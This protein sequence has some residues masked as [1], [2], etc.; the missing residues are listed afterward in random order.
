[1]IPISMAIYSQIILIKTKS[2]TNKQ[3]TK[4]RMH[5]RQLVNVLYPLQ[6]LMCA[7]RM[8]L[9]QKQHACK[10]SASAVNSWPSLPAHLLMPQDC[11]FP[12]P[13]TSPSHLFR[14]EFISL[15]PYNCLS[16][17]VLEIQKLEQ[18]QPLSG[19]QFAWVTLLGLQF[20]NW[21]QWAPHCHLARVCRIH[22]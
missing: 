15:I 14:A 4:L 18:S 19:A 17:P 5:R 21:P 2:K 7:V 9:F 11:S 3:N 13:P 8:F 22:T 6:L 12:S 10:Y 20:G 1:M 16:N